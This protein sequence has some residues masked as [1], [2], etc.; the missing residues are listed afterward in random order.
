MIFPAFL[1]PIASSAGMQDHRMGITERTTETSPSG[2]PYAFAGFGA[3]A[4]QQ[5]AIG[6]HSGRG[7][8]GHGA[9]WV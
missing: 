5:A 8:R 7:H 4:D 2:S 3:G 6:I 9:D 1:L